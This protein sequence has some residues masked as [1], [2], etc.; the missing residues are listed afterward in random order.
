MQCNYEAKMGKETSCGFCEMIAL[1]EKAEKSFSKSRK[2]FST[3][4]EKFTVSGDVYA[5]E[6]S[7][8]TFQTEM[9]AELNGCKSNKVSSA[10]NKVFFPKQINNYDY[11]IILLVSVWV[12]WLRQ[13]RL[14]VRGRCWYG[15]SES[16]I[17]APQTLSASALWCLCVSVCVH[18]CQD[19]VT[20][21]CLVAAPLLRRIIW[22]CSRRMRSHTRACECVCVREREWEAVV[23]GTTPV[24]A[25]V[26]LPYCVCVRE[27]PL[28]LWVFPLQ[29]YSRTRARKHTHERACSML[30]AG[31]VPI[32]LFV[33][34]GVGGR[35]PRLSVFGWLCLVSRSFSSE[36]QGARSSANF[37]LLIWDCRP[38]MPSSSNK[39]MHLTILPGSYIAEEV[40][41][42][43]GVLNKNKH[44]C[45]IC[46]NKQKNTGVA[47]FFRREAFWEISLHASSSVIAELSENKLQ[48]CLRK[49]FRFCEAE[50]ENKQ[51]IQKERR[52]DVSSVKTTALTFSNLTFNK[53]YQ[54]N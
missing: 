8:K 5:I 10:G 46:K 1:K 36:Q 44:A 19:T 14:D 15:T 27:W 12:W 50:H 45:K 2:F 31:K 54:M 28:L 30:Q 34:Q 32:L 20:D 13:Q 23:C 49:N 26:M 18:A 7:E 39:N 53:L 42:W 21:C 29:V 17:K 33:H 47:G 24:G 16:Q 41:S 38:L 37:R 11:F 22:H 6:K 35:T 9:G 51:D 40:M 43:G 4:M 25:T 52:P 48:I 3:S